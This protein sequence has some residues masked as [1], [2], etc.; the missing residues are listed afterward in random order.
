MTLRSI[1]SSPPGTRVHP[2]TGSFCGST[3][4]NLRRDSA[5]VRSRNSGFPLRENSPRRPAFFISR[6]STGLRQS[7]SA[8]DWSPLLASWAL[9]YAFAFWQRLLLSPSLYLHKAWQ[10]GG[11]IWQRSVLST[12]ASVGALQQSLGLQQR[13]SG[14]GQGGGGVVRTASHMADEIFFKVL[15]L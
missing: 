6:R 9:R 10:P 3:G 15:F 8:V 14:A 5:V 13:H 7:L 4:S 11:T 1:V 12:L 2:E